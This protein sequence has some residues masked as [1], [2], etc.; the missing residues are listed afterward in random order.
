VTY[1]Q[2]NISHPLDGQWVEVLGALYGLPWSNHIFW[3]DFDKTMAKASFF[4][5]QIPGEHCP[6][7][8]IDNHI[9]ARLDPEDPAKKLIVCV[10]ADD[11]L[12]IGQD[13]LIFEQ[14]LFIAVLKERYGDNL[15]YK[16]VSQDFCGSRL[17]RAPKGT[18]SFDLQKFILK[19]VKL[20]GLENEPGAT[21]PSRDDLF[22][23]PTDTSPA[24]HSIYSNIMGK[25]TFIAQVRYDVAKEATHLAKGISA[26]TV[27]DMEK[28]VLVIQYL[29][30]TSGDG[31]T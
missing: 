22:D 6:S 7:T 11:G 2:D 31:P 25:L 23:A 28:L 21:A 3:L 4:P 18:L 20:A 1:V 26:P 9:Y 5:I 10:T 8:P 29:Q 16:E 17:T 14:E 19:T 15:T 13:A 24:D 30:Y 12:I 27:S